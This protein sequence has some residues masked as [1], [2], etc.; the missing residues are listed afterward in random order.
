[1][2]WFARNQDH[3]HVVF[4]DATTVTILNRAPAA[5]GHL[6]VFPRVHY[7]DVW[8]VPADLYGA[9]YGAVRQAAERVRSRLSP[10]GLTIVEAVREPGWQSIA[11][12]H[13]HVVPRWRGDALRLP[14]TDART[15]EEPELAAVKARLLGPSGRR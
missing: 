6:L 7:A 11:H 3:P 4:A 9:V 8:G 1:M 14:W 5:P 10:D 15:H 13:V 2:C 12:L